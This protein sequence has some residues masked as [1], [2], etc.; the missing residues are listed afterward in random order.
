MDPAEPE[1]DCF[2]YLRY[3]VIAPVAPNHMNYCYAVL[4]FLVAAEAL[5]AVQNG[6]WVSTVIGG[7]LCA[8]VQYRCR[9]A[10]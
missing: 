1:R 7:S 8:C 4:A 3:V 2:G 10:W 6:L 5:V 9:G